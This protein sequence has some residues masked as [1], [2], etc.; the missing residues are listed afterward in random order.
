M[1]IV[2]KIKTELRYL[3]AC[4]HSFPN[5]YGRV[6]AGALL[7]NTFGGI[8]TQ[9]SFQHAYY[10]GTISSTNLPSSCLVVIVILIS[11]NDTR[12]R[13]V[14]RTSNIYIKKSFQ[15]NHINVSV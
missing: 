8:K 12:V 3:S 6:Y 5:K 14:K 2:W 9:I 11:Q 15:K 4:I 7:V 10:W 13:S 1:S